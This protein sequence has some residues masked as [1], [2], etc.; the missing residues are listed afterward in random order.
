MSDTAIQTK[1]VLIIHQ[2]FPGQFRSIALHLWQQPNIKVIGIGKESAPGIPDFPWIKYKLHRPASKEV[3]P[4]NARS[5]TAIL[6]GQGVLK[7]LL[8]LKER[9]FDV[10]VILAHPGWGET[11]Y[12]KEVFPKAKLIHFC[13]W[14]HNTQGADFGFDPEFQPDINAKLKLHT[15]NALH[16]L[17]LENC[18]VAISPT[19]WQKSQFPKIYQQ[20]IHVIHEGIPTALLRPNLIARMTLPNGKQVKYGDKVITYV[21]RNL[22]PYRGFHVFMRA[23]PHLLMQHPDCEVIIVG[24]DKVSYG[25]PP[26][27][28][29]NWRVKML[30][31]LS[32]SHPNFPLDRVHFLGRIPYAD[33]QTV[34]QVS[35]V[36]LYLTYP[37][38][39][40]WSLLEA[41][42]SG[43]AIVAS[44]TQPVREVIQ[45]EKNGLLVD[46]FSSAQLIQAIDTL[47]TNKPLAQHLRQ[48]AINTA[49]QYD[50]KHGIDEYSKLIFESSS[51]IQ[52]HSTSAQSEQVA[53]QF[54]RRKGD[55]LH[56]LGLS[57]KEQLVLKFLMSGMED[58]DISYQLQISQKTVN[59]HVS[60]IMS[61][62]GANNR[63]HVLAKIFS[64]E[65]RN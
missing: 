22:E 60:N 33:Y 29:A 14:Y 30:W 7:I 11:L 65:L 32:N 17:N 62:L 24:G 23:L 16:L 21:A 46:F 40:S 36:H 61:K 47:L 8:H 28:A 44:N 13:E 6:H 56:N 2:N 64:S 48:Q 59:H 45:H 15:T 37:F 49:Q 57:T 3:H 26:N 19:H 12:V 50:L 41:M 34:L 31:E 18:D 35:A 63:T 1:N 20:K 4:Y 10:D 54:N 5:E 53:P 51:N 9:G 27:D 55:K 25:A 42:A 58:R 39:L 52:T 43:C 38:V